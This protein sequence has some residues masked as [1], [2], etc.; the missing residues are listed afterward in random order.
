MSII[1][2]NLFEPQPKY[3][4]KRLDPH[5]FGLHSTHISKGRVP[6][7][8]LLYSF[9]V[10]EIAFFSLMVIPSMDY[11]RKPIMV[12]EQLLAIDLSTPDRRIYFPRLSERDE[13]EGAKPKTEK[14]PV[15]DTAA[16]RTK[17]L[18]YPGPQP[19]ISDPPNPTNRIQTLLQPALQNPPV[20]QA[21]IPLPNIIQITDAGPLPKP[22]VPQLQPLAVPNIDAPTLP[23][24]LKPRT[25]EKNLLIPAPTASR[26]SIGANPTLPTAAPVLAVPEK[27]VELTTARKDLIIT[28]PSQ[29]QV[30]RPKIP[31]PAAAVPGAEKPIDQTFARAD[32][33]IPFPS[34]ARAD[35]SRVTLVDNTPT[36]AVPTPPRPVEPEPAK[37]TA[38]VAPVPTEGPDPRNLLSISPL[39]P[40]PSTTV[41]VPAG[42]ARG[43]VAISPD[44][45]LTDPGTSPGAKADNPPAAAAGLGTKPDGIPGGASAKNDNSGKPG[46]TAGANAPGAPD[47]TANARG[48]A[49]TGAGTSS[50]GRGNA[51]GDA[52]ARSPFPG[53]TI[54]GGRLE[55]GVTGVVNGSSS[56]TTT[57]NPGTPPSATP[58][59]QYSLTI[60]STASSGGG[61]PDLGVFSKERVYTVYIDMQ[62]KANPAALPWTLQYAPTQ[63]TSNT[64]AVLPPFPVTKQ[65]PAF[66]VELLRKYPRRL[67]VVYGVIGTDG[68]LQDI[69]VKQSPDPALN[70]VA[71]DA[72][73]KWVFRPAEL[74]NSPAAVKI[75]V[76]IPL[77][78]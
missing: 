3:P 41:R 12:E 71:I 67:V 78:L 60:V 5:E 18:T 56:R 59:R 38:Q 20:I 53:I 33:A 73:S 25:V 48:A 64:E 49:A 1:G 35:A 54:Q 30:Q 74:N 26:P 51:S 4:P 29:V 9:L 36:P 44:P 61:L 11:F 14:E 55:N 42:E 50:G 58:N 15:A 69:A 77:G 57:V 66:P 24:A 13:T 40:P 7:R 68:K 47:G 46:N 10:H 2:L 62:D 32:L 17:G 63:Q 8:G 22:R 75:L 70:Q 37:P 72:L 39:Q 43:R 31:L 45:N 34:Q 52:P 28:A 16:L 6:G 27:P 23:P 21:P 65:Q 76:G 19:I